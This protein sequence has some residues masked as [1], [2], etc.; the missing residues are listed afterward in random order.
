MGVPANSMQVLETLVKNVFSAVRSA[1]VDETHKHL[2]V[3]GFD[4]EHDRNEL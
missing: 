3:R 4:V 2:I 1:G